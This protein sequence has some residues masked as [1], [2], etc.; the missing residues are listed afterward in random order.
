LVLIGSRS[1]AAAGSRPFAGARSRSLAGTAVAIVLTFAGVAACTTPH[2]ATGRSG[3]A[4]QIATQPQIVAGVPTGS[5]S[6]SGSASSSGK[7][8]AAA[9]PA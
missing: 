5:P 3:D 4:P 8:Y 1:F 7:P 6:P 2:R 9:M